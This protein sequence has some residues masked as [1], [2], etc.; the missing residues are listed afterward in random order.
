MR[1][2]LYK[3]FQAFKLQPF[4]EQVV[5]QQTKCRVQWNLYSRPAVQCTREINKETN[6]QFTSQI[7]GKNLKVVQQ[8]AMQLPIIQREDGH[9]YMGAVLK[10]KCH[11]TQNF[12]L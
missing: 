4:T 6:N 7:S 1:C 8:G 5:M 12:C 11:C 9:N 3:C 2:K 10:Y